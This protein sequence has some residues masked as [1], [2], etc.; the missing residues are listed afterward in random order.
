M[1]KMTK[2][3]KKYILESTEWQNAAL[4]TTHPS[5]PPPVKPPKE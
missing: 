1:S 2:E 3:E 5:P 4:K